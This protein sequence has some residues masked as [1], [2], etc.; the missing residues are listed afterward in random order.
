M[1]K[2]NTAGKYIKIVI[3]LLA[4]SSLFALAGKFAA[5]DVIHLKNGDKISGVV[6]LKDGMVTVKPPYTEKLLIG[7]KEIQKID[8]T[9]GK[10]TEELALIKDE[11]LQKACAEKINEAD[12]PNAGH[13]T[14]YK[15][16]NYVYNEDHTVVTESRSIIKVL[17]ERSLDAANYVR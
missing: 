15:E 6:S 14:L 16:E 10:D 3:Y 11:A 12:Y 8:I 4:I 17:K 13:V 5:A 1:K 9:R 7:F 2:K